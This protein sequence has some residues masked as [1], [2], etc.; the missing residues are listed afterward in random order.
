MILIGQGCSNEK[1]QNRAKPCDS[2]HPRY[3]GIDIIFVLQCPFFVGTQLKD[4][5]YFQ[6]CSGR[7]GGAKIGNG[8]DLK[9]QFSRFSSSDAAAVRFIRMA[10]EVLAARGDEKNGC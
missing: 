4:Q 3:R 10:C 1:V 8:R 7:N 9:P 2:G 6:S 5:H